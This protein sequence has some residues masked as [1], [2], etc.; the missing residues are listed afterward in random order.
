MND[1][2]LVS[3]I[4]PTYNRA[5]KLKYA[6]DSVLAQSY[7]NVQLIVIDDGSEDQ[8]LVLMKDY[9][10]V[11]YIIQKHAG[12]AAARNNGLRHS[13]GEILA[14]LDSD[15]TWNHD[16]LERC[17]EK[18]ERDQLDFV[19]ANWIQE[20]RIGKDWNFLNGD[21]FL[22]PYFKSTSDGWITLSY[23]ELRSIYIEACPSP[24]SSVVIR[25][26]SIV[27]GWDERINVCDDW[28][29]YLDVILS[30]PRK[31]AFT[32]DTL[33]KKRLDAINIYDGRKRNEVLK[34]LYIE[35][36]L[37][38]MNKFEHLLTDREMV[39]LKRRYVASLVELA[40]H[41]LVREHN[42]KE[43]LRLLK[44]SVSVD[45]LFTLKMIPEI[46][47]RGLRGKLKREDAKL[48]LE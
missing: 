10:T 17:V 28:C 36:T 32:L 29:M 25:K 39:L 8:T 7:N 15:D 40:K 41:E 34:F 24:S 18:L 35:D 46:A 19:F 22:I 27:S 1:S 20:A 44:T 12:Q 14:S 11:E 43:S 23:K 31:V 30:K 4:I 2:P 16:F 47:M 6:I 37:T 45:I 38:I 3:V 21:P 33:W 48:T 5:E 26:S 9:P 42:L 13:K